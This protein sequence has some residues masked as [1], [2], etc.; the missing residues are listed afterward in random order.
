MTRRHASLDDHLHV[1]WGAHHFDLLRFLS[2]RTPSVVYCQGTR[3]PGQNFKSLMANI[4]AVEFP[5]TLRACVL[6]NQ[7]IQSHPGDTGDFRCRIEGTLGTI[8]ATDLARDM[9]VHTKAWGGIRQR[10]EWTSMESAG[11]VAGL[12]GGHAAHM[13][14]LL[15]A[16]HERREPISSGR[17]NLLTVATCLAAKRSAEEA[18]PVSTE[19][20]VR[21]TG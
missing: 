16:I 15:N 7:V 4:Y 11:G 10:F 2:G 3:M 8:I 12:V 19:E 1:E 13:V 17:D 5:G 14:D 20:I 6:N 9:A 18:R 21:E